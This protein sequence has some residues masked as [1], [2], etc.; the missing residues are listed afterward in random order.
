MDGSEAGRRI[1]DAASGVPVL[2]LSASAGP[3][4]VDA[5][6]ESGCCDAFIAKPAPIETIR[7]K[8]AELLDPAPGARP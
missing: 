1:K 5:L 3:E 2:V 7:A 8:V 6:R 4:A